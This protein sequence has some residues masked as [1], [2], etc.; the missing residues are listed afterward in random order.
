MQAC[1][2]LAYSSLPCSS[3]SQHPCQKMQAVTVLR[4][5]WCL[6]VD[7]NVEVSNKCSLLK[8][9]EYMVVVE[10]H[11]CLGILVLMGLQS[12]PPLFIMLLS[13]TRQH[14]LQ[15]QWCSASWDDKFLKDR[16]A[17]SREMHITR[18]REHGWFSEASERGK[19]RVET[20]TGIRCF[21]TGFNRSSGGLTLRTYNSAE[22][23][24]GDSGPKEYEERCTFNKS[25]PGGLRA[26]SWPWDCSFCAEVGCLGSLRRCL[27]IWSNIT[28]YSVCSKVW[29]FT[30]EI[31]NF[32][33]L[34]FYSQPLPHPTPLFFFKGVLCPTGCELQTTL[35]KQEKSMKP[36]VHDLKDKVS[37]LSETST[38]FYEYVTLLDGKLEQQQK[39]RKGML[40][41]WFNSVRGIVVLLALLLLL[42]SGTFLKKC[43][44]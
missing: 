21:L 1:W 14:W 4:V 33:Y 22:K 31:R 6:K 11:C 29:S 40:F 12:V 7:L 2:E 30:D 8:I 13:L 20:Y 16:M 36:V 9:Y 28:N 25:P 18:Y 32:F 17:I 24:K 39:Q 35:L 44:I 27:N 15:K 41:L 38:T 34:G 19:G 10:S 37:K 5:S 3:L 42:V 43:K 26:S 23:W